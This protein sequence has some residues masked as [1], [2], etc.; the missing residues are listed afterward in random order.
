MRNLSSVI[1]E[2]LQRVGRPIRSSLPPILYTLFFSLLPIIASVIV[3]V[4]RGNGWKL[5]CQENIRNGELF[6]VAMS[7]IASSWFIVTDTYRKPQITWAAMPFITLIAILII[8]I[9]VL[10][11]VI[12]RTYGD[13]RDIQSIS[14]TSGVSLLLSCIVYARSIS[15]KENLQDN[16]TQV[17]NDM[18]QRVSSRVKNGR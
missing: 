6:I 16:H 10:C 5:C 1:C 9:S 2:W 11:V 12:Q 3:A 18:V 15:F 7:F 13:F 17:E 8:V 4:L 14:W